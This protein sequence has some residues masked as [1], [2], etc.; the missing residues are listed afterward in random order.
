MY[1]YRI[2]RESKRAQKL[3]LSIFYTKNV[4]SVSSIIRIGPYYRLSKQSRLSK[5]FKQS[6]VQAS[7]MVVNV[8]SRI[9]R[10]SRSVFSPPISSQNVII[11][12]PSLQAIIS[13]GGR[14]GSFCVFI[15]CAP[16]LV[17]G[18]KTLVATSRLPPSLWPCPPS[19]PIEEIV[20]TL[21][22]PKYLKIF[23]TYVH[24]RIK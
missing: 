1:M 7:N 21:A 12:V 15:L 10:I 13:S 22:P 18:H 6:S 14:V 19:G 16:Y 8:S 4:V 5:K 24:V 2:I 23:Y 20:Y 11:E 17:T 3:Q 9:E